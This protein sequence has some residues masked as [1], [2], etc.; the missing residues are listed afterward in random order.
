MRQS[1]RT[2]TCVRVGGNLVPGA[3]ETPFPVGCVCI[4]TRIPLAINSWLHV[5]GCR[6]ACFGTNLDTPVPWSQPGADTDMN[7][8]KLGLAEIV[9]HSTKREPLG[10]SYQRG[11]QLPQKVRHQ[12]TQSPIDDIRPTWYDVIYILQQ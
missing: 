8:L 5:D 2:Y 10:K 1:L 11:H 6:H 9:Y 12:N 4:R 7:R 3:T